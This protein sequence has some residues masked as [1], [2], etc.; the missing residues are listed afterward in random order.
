VFRHWPR[1]IPATTGLYGIRLPGRETRMAEPAFGALPP[2]VEELTP[3]LADEVVGSPYVFFGHSLGA[4]I[5]FAVCREFRRNGTPLPDKLIVSGAN[6][7]HLPPRRPP[8]HD[9]PEPEFIE[10]LR[11]LEG[12]PDEALTNKELMEVLIPMLRAD[13]SVSETYD[14][15]EEPPLPCPI[16]A[17][18]GQDDEDVPVEDV[19][20]WRSHTSS[21]FEYKIFP[22]GHFFI[23]TYEM[24][25]VNEVT[26]HT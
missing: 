19:H 20:A 23:H 26:K 11:R 22:G 24:D 7:P 21:D 10:E 18:G 8:I 5:A 15:T 1:L 25:V 4:L 9:L 16:A 13:C 3:I 14:Y 6:A 17:F 12:T 2:L